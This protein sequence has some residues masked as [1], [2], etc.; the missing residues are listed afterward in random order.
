VSR[1]ASKLEA[2]K[3]KQLEL[4]ATISALVDGLCLEYGI[5]RREALEAI[6]VVMEDADAL[7]SGLKITFPQ[8]LKR[9]SMTRS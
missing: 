2:K 8:A 6:N 5:D 9:L 3:R 1:E 4:D 7:M